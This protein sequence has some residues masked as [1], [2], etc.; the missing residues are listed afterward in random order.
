VKHLKI[1]IISKKEDIEDIEEN[2]EIVHFAFR[3]SIKDVLMLMN[4]TP[5]L[6]LIEIPK[7][8]SATLSKGL[9]D[10]FEMKDITLV[11][12]DVWGHRSDI[13][14]Y[15]H[16]PTERITELSKTGSSIKEISNITKV[17]EPMVSYVLN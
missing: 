17:N 5:E 10:I 12:S 11:I 13:D 8:Y 3:P 16:I 7:S 9:H 1:R 4:R 14:K 2:E 6:S 15:V